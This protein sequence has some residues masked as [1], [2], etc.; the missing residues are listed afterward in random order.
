[1]R[2]STVVDDG[3][4]ELLLLMHL[5]GV[6][7][8]VEGVWMKGIVEEITEDQPIEDAMRVSQNKRVSRDQRS[9]SRRSN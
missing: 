5:A 2:Q 4:R 8:I 9:G 3:G 7:R 1:M 6:R